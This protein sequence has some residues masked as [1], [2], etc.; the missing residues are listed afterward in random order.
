MSKVEVAS[1]CLSFRSLL[2][3][4]SWWILDFK[5][6]IVESFLVPSLV[7]YLHQHQTYSKRAEISSSWASDAS[8]CFFAY[9][10]CLSMFALAL[11]T[12]SV[13]SRAASTYNLRLVTESLMDLWFLSA[14]WCFYFN[15]LHEKVHTDSRLRA[16]IAICC[17]WP[18]CQSQTSVL[19]LALTSSLW[20]CWIHLKV[21]SIQC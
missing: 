16:I 1:S 15:S 13:S 2:R 4:S 18:A 12:V 7:N 3:I 14:S 5:A 21:T 8:C 6:S 19:S 10:S 11:L 17:S 9:F 20:Y